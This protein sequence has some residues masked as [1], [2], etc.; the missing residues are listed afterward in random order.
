MAAE[1][2]DDS[3]SGGGGD[4]DLEEEDCIMLGLVSGDTVEYE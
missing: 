4:G 2:D 3:E 1:D